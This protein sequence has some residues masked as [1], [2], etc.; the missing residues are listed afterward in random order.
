MDSYPFILMKS[1]SPDSDKLK[2]GVTP[3]KKLVITCLFL[4]VL[5]SSNVFSKEIYTFERMWPTMEGQWYF[6]KPSG[7]AIDSEGFVYIAD[8]QNHYIHKLSADGR[9]VTRWGRLGSGSGE[10]NQPQ[11][12][13]IDSSNIV[14]VADCQNN[15]IQ[16][17]KS[18]GQ[19]IAAYGTS[20]SGNG[21]FALPYGIAVGVSGDIYVTEVN[22][23]RVQRFK[24]DGRF[25]GKWGTPGSGNGEFNWPYGIAV[26]GQGVVYVADSQNNR[27][28]KFSA[29]GIF[30]QNLGT[31]GSNTGEF[32]WPLGI[33]ADNTGAVYITDM[34]NHRVQKFGKDGKIDT[35]G[36]MGSGDRQFYSPDGIA[37]SSSGYIYVADSGNDRIQKFTQN[38]LFVGKW[39]RGSNTGEFASPDGIAIAKNGD[40]YVADTGN[41]RIQKFT[42][43]REF[44]KVFDGKFYA[45]YRMTIDKEGN[46]YVAD[47]G[48]NRIQKFDADGNFLLKWGRN[49]KENGQFS[50]PYGI[51]ADSRGN[52]YVTDQ[53]N[54]RI[55]KF[56]KTGQYLT[57]WGIKGS[58]AGEFNQPQGI[59]TD[60][61]DNIYVADTHNH[62]IQK[63]DKDMNFIIEWGTQGSGEGQFDQPNAVTIDADGS[64]YITDMKNCRIQ[65]F[66]FA[67]GKPELISIFGEEGSYPGQM[68]YPGA[69]AIGSDGNFY[70]A[71]N[72]NH[73]IQMF[74]KKADQKLSKAIIVAG[75]GPY[76]GNKLW[77]STRISA[78]FAY[79][80]VIYQGFEK[81][82][83]QY[84]SHDYQKVDLD[85]NGKPD[86]IAG[87]P[88]VENIRK[89]MAE[90]SEDADMLVVY[91]TD[92]G[93]DG[94]FVLSGTE[95][96]SAESL[97]DWLNQSR[98]KK[99]K[100]IIVIYDACKSGT[101]HTAFASLS[102]P[103]ILMSSTSGT[104]DAYFI[105][106]GM[107]SFSG[108]F[109]TNIL[110]GSPV[111]AAFD[112]AQAAVSTIIK[113]QIPR[114]DNQGIP[115]NRIIG[116]GTETTQDIPVIT[117]A[118]FY[119]G[120][121]RVK[122]ADKDGISR[123]WAVMKPEDDAQTSS[124][125]AVT[126]M[127]SSDLI[128]M[129]NGEYTG[130]YQ[131]IMPGSMVIYA[132]DL[133]GNISAKELPGQSRLLRRRAVIVSGAGRKNATTA[134]NALKNQWYADTDIVFLAPSDS[135]LSC[136]NNG[137]PDKEATL[138]N[139]KDALSDADNLRD[140]TLY[141]TGSGASGI[142]R[143][144]DKETLTA[145][146][147]AQWVNALQN[148]IPGKITVIYDA[149][150]ARSFLTA[151][152]SRDRIVIASASP[153]QRAFSDTDMSF[154][155][156]FWNAVAAGASVR[157]AFSDAR[158]AVGFL[159]DVTPEIND[160]NNLAAVYYIGNG[161]KMAESV[162]ILP[163]MTLSGQFSAPIRTEDSSGNM[164]G[165]W[166]MITP[167]G[168]HSELNCKPV[169]LELLPK[170]GGYE[171]L[172]N[173]FKNFGTYHIS[174]YTRDK[175]G[176]ISLS[177]ETE[178]YQS[179][180][181]DIYEPDND[182]AHASYIVINDRMPQEHNFGNSGDQ[183]W[184]KFCGV[185][186]QTYTVRASGLGKDCNPVFEIY[187]RNFKML[188]SWRSSG[189]DIV[190]EWKCVYDGIYY[191]KI[192]N[193]KTGQDTGYHLDIYT[194][195][196]ALPGYLTGLI[197]DE[198]G[199]PIKDAQIKTDVSGSALSFADGQYVMNQ[200]AGSRI[201]VTVSVP[202]YYDRTETI[203][204]S[205]GGIA[206]LNFSLSRIPPETPYQP[207]PEEQGFI[208]VGENLSLN[209]C[210][211]YHG[212][213]FGMTMTFA[214][215]PHGLSGVFWKA[216]PATLKQIQSSSP[217][218]IDVG[219]DLA[220]NIRAEY[221]GIRYEFPM[222]F[223]PY[224]DAASASEFFWKADPASLRIIY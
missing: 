105:S 209:I 222:S 94:R 46:V 146:T 77:D 70:V 61:D 11:G 179:G 207:T 92:H 192:Y 142:F 143:I 160:P 57:Q 101:F 63:F 89:A 200:P 71:D 132:K 38:G 112:S 186:G 6:N 82:N 218:C 155:G 219:N 12:I 103:R 104:E 182:S 75:G 30:I 166:V 208:T 64:I 13:A 157:Q 28:Q 91:L 55:Q 151:L 19:F 86:D 189:E 158:N 217:A 49:G 66:G 215:N 185:A 126:D 3:M 159:S 31:S 80:V 175:S 58:N 201:T 4:T 98:G 41:N 153:E 197:T 72:N 172:Y 107:I 145:A 9:L 139:L 69:G 47:S 149:D 97:R 123:V 22:N 93:G 106:Q 36:V 206:S 138:S 102:A 15:R 165:A 109:W 121:L 193:Q 45:P 26:D 194:P 100:E 5:F 199:N 65:K 48:N 150:Y 84:F 32:D 148:K 180:G 81:K 116:N 51:A 141:L 111:K 118:S 124:G 152:S 122:A 176:N 128:F 1:L 198:Q 177:G 108:F 212:L 25:I 83:I 174:V 127:P 62:R 187:D 204:V 162:T 43:D 120:T 125:S 52:V 173:D 2:K 115:E 54:S 34:N 224:P 74:K 67:N 95:T 10:F 8:S 221:R 85:N 135:S 44:I 99:Y 117:E 40:I 205:E 147:L 136:K 168:C 79:Q 110:N 14:Y 23:N 184:M 68:K 169:R 88:T 203:S 220:M 188:K 214:P 211:R 181:Q 178:I 114:M 213:I 27:I 17:F 196:A 96:V 140:L 170:T 137:K 78:N 191:L 35:W 171:A 131:N 7:I 163:D 60:S 195:T 133:V 33:A 29:D 223:Y 18:N 37:I 190:Q 73:R 20:G 164:T 167:P 56:D 130:D 161:I 24:T 154:S 119:G 183:D 144:N 39:G 42:K 90:W 16:K 156:F 87:V 129:G 202:G 210:V 113:V 216:D 134:C 53:G 21:Q 50:R 59:A 76:P